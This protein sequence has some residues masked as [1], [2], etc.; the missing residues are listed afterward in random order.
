MDKTDYII[1]VIKDN[2]DSDWGSTTVS[3]VVYAWYRD[4]GDSLPY[5]MADNG[6]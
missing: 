2:L 4:S 1:T 5:K 6:I 3:G